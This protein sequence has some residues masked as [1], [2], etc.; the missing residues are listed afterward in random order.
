MESYLTDK[1]CM[2]TGGGGSIG[3]EI[4][5]AL[6]RLNA[7][8]VVAVDISENG[9][10]DVI[11]DVGG[12]TAEIA[13]VRDAG[14]MEYLFDKYR[15]NI[16][17]HA[18]AH[19]HVPFMERNPEEA[20]KNNIIGTRVTAELAEKY[21]AERFV[22]ISTDKAVEPVSVMGATK[23]VCEML[24]YEMSRSA[25]TV[26][27]TVRF[28]NVLGSN[29]SVVPLFKKQ[30]EKG[31][32]TVTDRNVERYFMTVERAASVVIS[33]AEHTKGGDVFVPDMGD[34]MKIIDLAEKLI[35]ESGKNAEIRV[36]SLRQGDKLT[37]K[38]FYD[39]ETPESCAVPGVYRVDG[40]GVEGLYEYT[41]RLRKMADACDRDGIRAV[42]REMTAVKG[43]T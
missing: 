2:V 31:V 40:S 39:F 41:D 14:K 5:R 32:V 42:L 11:T 20:V 36:T 33:C 8:K 22:L 35:E 28:G 21:G 17:F 23:R 13:S 37:E 10:Y 26:F 3:G 29:G 38:L 43:L 1:V 18:A 15:P 30:I 25:K 9:L 27:T 6:T 16:V 7:A 12:V 24:M 4:V 34:S 19:K